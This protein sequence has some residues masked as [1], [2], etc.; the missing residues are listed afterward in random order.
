MIGALLFFSL[1]AYEKLT[2]ESAEIP[3]PENDNQTDVS[4]EEPNE[5]PPE[6]PIDTEPPV[7]APDDVKPDDEQEAPLP[8]EEPVD[9]RTRSG[10]SATILS[11]LLSLAV[12]EE[13][14]Y[15]K[16]ANT[17]Y[18]GLFDYYGPEEW[19]AEFIA[20]CVASTEEIL[21]VQLSGDMFP[22]SD[23]VTDCFLWFISHAQFDDSGKFTP[24]GGDYVFL[25]LDLD[26]QIDRMGIV[27]ETKTVSTLDLYGNSREKNIISVLCGNMPQSNK[28]ELFEIDVSDKSIS[29]FGIIE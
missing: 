26:G 27:V 7:E 10:S 29:G 28:I 16:G 8:D 1:M 18:T 14:Y 12:K 25:D 11:M 3:Q 4:L 17:K 21:S 23:S 20:W 15:H 22:W 9:K 19:S 6:E 2:A 24:W 5:K 13:G